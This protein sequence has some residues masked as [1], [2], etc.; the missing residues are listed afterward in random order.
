MEFNQS[1][2]SQ[3]RRTQGVSGRGDSRGGRWKKSRDEK[4]RSVWG[5]NFFR[6]ADLQFL[7]ARHRAEHHIQ[8]LHNRTLQPLLPDWKPSRIGRTLRRCRLLNIIKPVAP[9]P[10][11]IRPHS[12]KVWSSPDDN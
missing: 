12:P 10:N 11:T 2:A 9:A 8:G 7:R 5:L 4:D 1:Y 3:L 6:A